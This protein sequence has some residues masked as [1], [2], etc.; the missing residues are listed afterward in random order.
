[1]SNKSRVIEN[2]KQFA[3]TFWYIEYTG[4]LLNNG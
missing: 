4:N 3:K 2:A 1:M